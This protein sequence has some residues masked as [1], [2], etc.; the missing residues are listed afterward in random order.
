[1]S[2]F[3][4]GK[5][6]LTTKDI[7]GSS[8]NLLSGTN[9]FNTKYFSIKNGGFET[10][11]DDFP[12]DSSMIKMASVAHLWG[13]DNTLSY[14]A[15]IS[16]DSGYYTLSFIYRWNGN[17]SESYDYSYKLMG[18]NQLLTTFSI[19][20]STGRKASK[21]KVNFQLSQSA[22]FNTISLVKNDSIGFPGG[23]FYVTDLK[24][25]TGSIA[26]PWACSMDDLTQRIE[27][28]EQKVK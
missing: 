21:F 24:L 1:M 26:T 19:K 16:L 13:F 23:S 28:L 27:A 15:P 18:D 17:P 3:I 10:I 25:E 11:A 12:D 5:E 14:N 7:A 9:D 4:S 22:S 6:M 2:V 8:F 20:G